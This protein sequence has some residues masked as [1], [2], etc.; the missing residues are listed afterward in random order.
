MQEKQDQAKMV[1]MS[2]WYLVA[3][4]EQERD[5]RV[6]GIR[7]LYRHGLLRGVGPIYLG[8]Q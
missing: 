4:A 3:S 7:G 5:K 2:I 6:S 8:E 1:T